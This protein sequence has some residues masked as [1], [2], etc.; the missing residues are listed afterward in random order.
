MYWCL[1]SN[2]KESIIGTPK[3]QFFFMHSSA[4]Y[5]TNTALHSNFI[6][7]WT[8]C[9]QKQVSIES[10]ICVF[11]SSQWNIKL[12]YGFEI[13]NIF[14]NNYWDFT[15]MYL[16]GKP[17]QDVY[18]R[19]LFDFKKFLMK[20]VKDKENCNYIFTGARERFLPR[21]VWY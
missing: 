8:F 1:L 17:H 13:L 18:R 16:I 12:L 7:L 2:R 19:N 4:T 3:Y 10:R 20:K 11:F 21:G 5:P 6:T 9:F 15:Y 14:T